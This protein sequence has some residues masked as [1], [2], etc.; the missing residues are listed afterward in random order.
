MSNQ[1]RL[2]VSLLS[3][4][5]GVFIVMFMWTLDK[6]V[7]PGHAGA[8]FEKVYGLSGLGSTLMLI[9]AS[10]EMLLILAFLVG[11]WKR[12]SYG[13][14]VLLHAG[15]TLSTFGL[16]LAPWQN[17]LFFAA[18]PMLAACL[19]LYLLRDEDRLFTLTKVFQRGRS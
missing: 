12:I 14:V 11:A 15:S 2:Q 19:A 3:L 5:A 6:F 17:L 18:W 8:V 4:R 16:Y 7:N 10:A 9:L 13:A 1:T